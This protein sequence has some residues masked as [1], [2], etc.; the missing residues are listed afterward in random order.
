VVSVVIPTFNG[1]PFLT[2]TLNSVISQTQK[3]AEIIV[4]DDASTDETTTL[5]RSFARSC[6]IPLRLMSTSRNSGG[7]SHPANLGIEAAQYEYIAL[8]D[9]DDLMRPRRIEAQVKALAAHPQCGLAIGR[10]S[11]MGHEEDDLSSLWPVHPLADL[12]DNM[13]DNATYSIIDSAVAFKPLL[14][15]NYG[16]SMSNFCVTKEWFRRVGKFDETVHT[17]ADLDFL[18][19]STL[20]GPLILVNEKTFCY[21]WNPNS[22]QHQ[23]VARSL[24]EATMVRLRVA[25]KKPEWAGNDLQ[26]LQRSALILAFAAVKK[27]NFRAIG[28]I[29]KTILK[30]GGL[31]AM[32]SIVANKTRRF[33][34]LPNR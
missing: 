16:A 23:D 30:Y 27:G 6:P 2:D 22:L 20:A 28:A 5:A 31:P 1:A 3:P 19:R 4:V 15:R 8:L 26:E 33:F 34:G 32:K 9:H 29:R 11:I 7:P 13:D 14:T 10:F 17:C 25:S 12:S 21:R 18:L 24:F